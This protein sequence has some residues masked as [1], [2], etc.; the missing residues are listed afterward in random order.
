M[1]D[2]VSERERYLISGNY[3]SIAS[4][5]E[6]K[7]IQT[8]ELL[9]KSYPRDDIAPLELGNEYM[10]LGEW[11]RALS[12]MQDSLRLEQNDVIAFS[13]LAEIHLALGHLDEAKGTFQQALGAT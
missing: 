7:A 12:E 1:R 5:D 6:E 9:T 4:G 10:L 2:R 3:Y 11:K 13:N 8:Y